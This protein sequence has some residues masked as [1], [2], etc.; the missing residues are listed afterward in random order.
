MLRNAT[1]FLLLTAI[2]LQGVFGSLQDSVSIC[3]GGGHEHDVSEVIEQCALE[4][5]HTSEWVTPITREDI[6]D[7]GCTDV[8]L[9]LIVLLSTHR[10]KEHTMQFDSLA[11]SALV[12]SGGTLDYKAWCGLPNIHDVDIGMMRSIDAIRSTRLRV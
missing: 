7:C 1:T 3:L 9:G 10:N 11:T 2:A 8:E 6:V 4:C 5:S 12:C